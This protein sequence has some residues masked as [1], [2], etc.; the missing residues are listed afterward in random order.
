MS[1]KLFYYNEHMN[2]VHYVRNV[3]RCLKCLRVDFLQWWFEQCSRCSKCLIF[4]YLSW[5]AIYSVE[6]H[7]YSWYVSKDIFCSYRPCCK[8]C[9][10]LP[11]QSDLHIKIYFEKVGENNIWKVQI[12]YN[13]KITNK[14]K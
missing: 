7:D 5:S 11:S 3:H 14:G 4:I 13:M 10:A 12:C 8:H 1:R 2:N 9:T 6:H